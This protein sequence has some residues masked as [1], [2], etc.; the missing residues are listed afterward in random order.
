[1]FVRHGI[2]SDVDLFRPCAAAV[3]APQRRMLL[4]IC[5]PIDERLVEFCAETRSIR[6]CGTRFPAA[7]SPN[8]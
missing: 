7:E 2:T 1:L 8:C 4:P 6:H 5:A 3:Q